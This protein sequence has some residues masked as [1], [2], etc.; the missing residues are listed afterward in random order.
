MLTNLYKPRAY[1]RDV[2]VS[3]LKP[4]SFLKGYKSLTGWGTNPQYLGEAG[5]ASQVTKFLCRTFNDLI[6]QF[7]LKQRTL[8]G[9]RYVRNRGNVRQYKERV[10]SL[11]ELLL[12]VRNR[13]IADRLC[14]Y[15]CD[16]AIAIF[17]T[18]HTELD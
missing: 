14:I 7:H 9:R 3:D 5:L 12:N 15:A 10:M 16:T 4:C 2:T 8:F 11:Y 1:I 13:L 18:I 17:P 6:A